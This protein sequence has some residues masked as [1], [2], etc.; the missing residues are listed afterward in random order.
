MCDMQIME[1]DLWEKI[2]H[3]KKR[4]EKFCVLSIRKLSVRTKQASGI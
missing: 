3:G 1:F 4:Y 2:Q